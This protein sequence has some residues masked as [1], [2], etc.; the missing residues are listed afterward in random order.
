MRLIT[1]IQL[2]LLATFLGQMGFISY[3]LPQMAFAGGDFPEDIKMSFVLA[4][5]AIGLLWVIKKLTYKPEP[6][7]EEDK[8]DTLP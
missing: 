1:T 5:L 3:Y 6:E 7:V 8:E 4:G 2:Y